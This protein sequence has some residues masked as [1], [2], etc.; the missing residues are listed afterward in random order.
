[1][2]VL[3]E[4]CVLEM[5]LFCFGAVLWQHL[6]RTAGSA[7]LCLLLHLLSTSFHV[8]TSHSVLR[9]PLHPHLPG[10]TGTADL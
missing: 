8:L 5:S 10:A 3:D 2:L 4:L 9:V 6:S 7:L 1:M